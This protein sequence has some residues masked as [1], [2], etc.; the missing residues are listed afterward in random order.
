MT[1]QIHN[2]NLGI[3]SYTYPFSCGTN[4]RIIPLNPFT[5]WDIIDKAVALQVPIV[6]IADNLPLEALSLPE[7]KQLKD[8]AYKNHITLE[9]GF[10]G[11]DPDHLF[12]GL[13]ITKALDSHLIR[14]VIDKPGFQPS[15][16]TVAAILKSALPYLETNKIT[17]GVENHDRFYS[18]QFA[19]I[20]TSVRHPH[21]GIIL[22]TANSLSKEESVDLVLDHLAPFIVGFHAKDYVIHRRLGEMGFVITGAPAGKGNLNIP[23]ILRRISRNFSNSFSIILESWM[24]SL[25]TLEDTLIQEDLWAKEGI[26]Y[27]KSLTI[28]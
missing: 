8:Y 23:S 22:D 2:Y 7:L 12:K 1:Y 6:Q 28:P 17:L 15:P 24:E 25:P 19:Q 14:F 9:T 16:E 18:H 10:R 4:K 3:S 13:E 21:V 20:M 27:L 26:T 5:P 11:L